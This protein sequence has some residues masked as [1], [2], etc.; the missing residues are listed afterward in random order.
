MK[1]YGQKKIEFELANRTI[2]ITGASG[3][4]GSSLV[5][6]L[7]SCDCNLLLWSRSDLPTLES[8][9]LVRKVQGKL[10]DLEAWKYVLNG[11]DSNRKVDHIIHLAAQT[12][13]YSAFDDPVFDYDI[14]ALPML[15]MITACKDLK[16]SPNVILAGTSTQCGL[17]Q[18]LPVTTKHPDNP[19]TIYDM[20]KWL[21]EKYLLLYAKKGFISGTSLRLTNVYGPGP[22]SSC[23]DR[24]VLNMMILRA[25]AGKDITIYGEGKQIR[26]YLYIDDAVEAFVRAMVFAEHLNTKYYIIGSGEGHSISEALQLVAERIYK[27]IYVHSNVLNVT[28]PLGLSAIEDRNFIADF[29]SFSS[30]TKWIPTIKLIQ[31]IDKT[32]AFFKSQENFNDEYSSSK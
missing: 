21:A 23:P 29:N 19:I 2:L 32:I 26:D 9:T 7:L 5:D 20:H 15:Q 31:G 22:M 25:L 12:S 28:A 8:N 17:P 27:S 30:I 6:R 18:I 24:G 4:I 10:T 3:Y 13:V 11:L 16:V 14:N 1:R